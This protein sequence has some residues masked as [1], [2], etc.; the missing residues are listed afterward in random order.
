[1]SAL[2]IVF[3][4]LA[5]SI[6]CSAQ[7]DSLQIQTEETIEDLLE[8][9]DEGTDNS[10]LYELIEHYL[11]NPLNLNKAS[12][13]ELSALPYSDLST[14]NLIIEHRNK[15][16]VIFSK[17]ELY[18][19]SAIPEKVVQ[20]ILPFITVSDSSSS[21]KSPKKNDL[22]NFTLQMRSRILNDLQR[23]RGFE[24]HKYEGS[25]YKIY[26][27]LKASYSENIGLGILT[28]KDAGEYSY[29]DFYSGYLKLSDWYGFKNIIMGDYLVE[30]GQGLALWSP[31]GLSKGTDAVYAVKK[32]SGKL[33]PYSSASENNFFRGAG[34]EYI[35]EHIMIAGFY[36][37]NLVDAN[38]DS[39]SGMV[40]STPL[41]GLHRTNT[42]SAKRKSIREI[43]YGAIM[44]YNISGSLSTGILYYTSLFNRSFYSSDIHDINGNKFKYYSIYLD[45]YIK[46]FNVFG[47]YSFSGNSVASINGL[48]FSPSPIFSYTLIIRNYP[49]NYINLHGYGFGER[50]GATQNEFGIYNGFRWRTSLGILNFYYDQFKFPYATTDNPLPSEGNEFM[51][52]FSSRLSKKLE[53]NTRIKHENKEVTISVDRR[54]HLVRRIKQSYRFELIYTL[55]DYIRF[56][57]RAEYSNY[58]IRDTHLSSEGYL[59]FEDVRIQPVNNLFIY[60]RAIFFQTD[61]YNSTIYEYENDLT[62]ILSTT[63]LSGEGVRFYFVIKYGLFKRINLSFKYSETY[64]PKETSIGTGYQEIEGNLDNRIGLQLDI[65][66]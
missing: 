28:D 60:G 12:L 31:Y 55:S 66:F 65:N 5:L 10:D 17:N 54:D 58:Y 45:L 26:N 42:E 20:K 15:Y 57:S 2:V 37:S 44:E 40:T 49:P 48:H 36:S 61:S 50:S 41:D 9:P 7:S 32:Q 35:W 3:I 52:N 21:N 27:R 8:E 18:S 4:F 59:F 62:G 29:Y 1:M 13:A 63:G 19:I 46:Y 53:A 64:K 34:T 22:S 33:K 6:T 25:P 30:F 23:R 38:I 56:K 24:A 11:N 14:A 16:G 43:S 51:V 39:I 47:E